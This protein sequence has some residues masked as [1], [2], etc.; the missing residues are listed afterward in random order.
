MLFRLALLATLT[1]GACVSPEGTPNDDTAEQAPADDTAAWVDTGGQL[2]YVDDIY[3]PFLEETCGGCHLAVGY[4]HPPITADP[5]HL[6]GAPSTNGM[7]YVTPGDPEESF[8]WYKVSGRQEEV[9]QGGARMPPYGQ[10]PLPADALPA[11]EAWIRSGA[12]P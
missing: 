10:A 7:A 2:S 6:V 3:H 12:A 9:D 8:L 5:A 1:M 4:T 11:I